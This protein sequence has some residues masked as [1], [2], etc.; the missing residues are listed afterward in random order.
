MR[1]TEQLEYL[2]AKP[3]ELGYVHRHGQMFYTVK[4]HILHR[5]TP[6]KSDKDARRRLK[7]WK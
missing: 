1:A 4:G 7:L 2:K 6:S 3:E 5:F